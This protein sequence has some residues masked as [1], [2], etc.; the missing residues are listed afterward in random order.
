MVGAV[1]RCLTIAIAVLLIAA[2]VF[3]AGG[4]TAAAVGDLVSAVALTAASVIS[5]MV[6]G[7]GSLVGGG[8]D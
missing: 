4:F 6:A 8:H 3:L 1:E 5:G 7:L 2:V